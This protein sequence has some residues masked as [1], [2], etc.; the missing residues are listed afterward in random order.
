MSPAGG[1]RAT[2]TRVDS[3]RPSLAVAPR[4][5]GA[6]ACRSA[7]P[8]LSPAPPTDPGAGVIAAAAPALEPLPAPAPAP[9]VPLG[10]GATRARPGGGV[11]AGGGA[12]HRAGADPE[13]GPRGL[14]VGRGAPRPGRGGRGP[15]RR[16]PRLRADA[17]AARERRRHVPAGEGGHPR[18]GRGPHRPDPQGGPPRGGTRLDLV[19]PRPADR[20]QPARPARDPEL[21]ERRARAVPRGLSPLGPLPAPDPRPPREGRPAEPA[22]LAA[23][24]RELVQGARPLAGQRARDVAVHLVDRRCAT[25]SAGT[26]GWTSGSTPRSPPTR[27]SRTSPTCTASSAT[28]PRPS[29]ATTAAR[30]GC[31][32][33]RGPR[34]GSTWTSGTSTSCCRAR[35]A[36]TCPGSSPRSRSSRIPR[37]TG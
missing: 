1:S 12:G 17:G 32:G 21:H 30:P 13:G 14:P 10:A 20:G 28:G 29:P 15:R 35:R 2:C 3:H 31:C 23:A 9:Q 6:A 11:G 18:P 34:T 26:T 19:G 7:A 8:A 22:E 5:L 33:S 37:S 4:L 25:A 16:G 24:R 27:R 36:A